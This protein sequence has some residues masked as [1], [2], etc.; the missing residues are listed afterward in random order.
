LDIGYWLGAVTIWILD[1]PCWLLDIGY[2][3]WAVPI[4]ILDILPHSG[5]PPG[6][7][8]ADELNRRALDFFRQALRP[9]FGV[10]HSCAALVFCSA[11]IFLPAIQVSPE[12]K[13]KQGLRTP[14]IVSQS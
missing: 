1:I 9:D 2:W 3:F 10:R 11:I 12:S 13:A 7:F 4:W 6:L 5:I 8:N 14:K